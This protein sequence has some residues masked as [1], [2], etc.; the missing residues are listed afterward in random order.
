MLPSEELLGRSGLLCPDS[1]KQKPLVRQA[2]D[3][4]RRGVRPMARR[5][6][7][8]GQ[9]GQG[10][11]QQKRGVDRIIGGTEAEKTLHGPLMAFGDGRERST[12][13]REL[14]CGPGER[15]CRSCMSVERGTRSSEAL[16]ADVKLRSTN[17]GTGRAGTA[18]VKTV[19]LLRAS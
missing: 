16:R 19:V 15:C 1:C 9:V 14:L 10:G 18:T 6:L 17:H 3:V 8:R 2:Q 5:P 11:G 12:G 7:S 4:V 13:S